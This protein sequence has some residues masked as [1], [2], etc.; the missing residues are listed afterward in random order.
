MLRTKAR[1][2]IQVSVLAP[3]S[4]A[5]QYLLVLLRKDPQLRPVLLDDLRSEGELDSSIFLVDCGG[6]PL[7]VCQCLTRLKSRDASARCIVLDEKDLEVERMLKWG[8]HGSLAYPDVACSLTR[9]VRAVASGRI[10]VRSDLLQD[11]VQR[12]VVRK[13]R[14]PNELTDREIEIIEFVKKRMS[15]DEIA[16]L[17]GIRN[18]TVKFHISNVLSKLHLSTRHDLQEE[19]NHNGVWAKFLRPSPVQHR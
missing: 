13:N 11:Y 9:A 5:G 17:L 14:T 7:P 8:G 16:S 2:P 19:P 12:S 6:L 18:T 15:N 1:T 3:H 10:W 4:L